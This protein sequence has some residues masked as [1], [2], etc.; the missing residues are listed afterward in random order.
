MIRYVVRR[1]AQGIFVLWAAFTASFVLL[2]LLPADPVVTMLGADGQGANVDPAQLEQV[3][4]QYG[5]D[6]PVLVQYA[7]RLVAALH[8]DFGSSMTTGIPVRTELAQAL[9]STAALAGVAVTLSVVL[10]ATIA[11]A[12]TSTRT[13]WLRRLLT[14]LPSLGVAVPTFWVALVLIQVVSFR[15]GLLPAFGGDGWRSLVLPAV[16]LAIPTSASMAQVLASSLDATWDSPFVQT[17]TAKGARRPRILTRHVLRN[18]VT[19]ALTMAAM[20]VGG[21]LAGSV[22]TETVFARPGLGRLTQQAVAAQDI[23][24]VQGVV[25]LAAVVFVLV[26][27]IVDA[28]QLGLDPRV[29]ATVRGTA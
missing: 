20:V 12:A 15:W 11:I 28:A 5:F 24:L 1:L 2:Y 3:R 9:P 8:G 26:N 18:A 22:V 25:V 4:R 14:S 17:A 21:V 29:A 7:H 16:T 6:Q 13:G 23:P 10:A 19:P 27:L